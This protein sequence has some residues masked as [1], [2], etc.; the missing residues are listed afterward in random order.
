MSR[1]VLGPHIS[2]L[3]KCLTKSIE[4]VDSILDA[5]CFQFFLS[6]PQA[7]SVS[8]TIPY[9]KRDIKTFLDYVD[10]SGIRP[11]VHGKYLYNF[12]HVSTGKFKWQE[13]SL[14]REISYANEL[15]ADIVIHQ[16]KNV[17]S[18]PNAD[19]IKTY[20]NGI[21]SV[22]DRTQGSKNKL[23]L[24]NSAHQGTELGHNMKELHDIW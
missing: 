13:E 8:K 19:A 15:G 18:I 10:L 11:I 2:I 22:L 24:E 6:S 1:L 21:I 3:N 14:I 5:N 16:G 23:V 20:V 9:D 17:E 12:C 4:F 7:F